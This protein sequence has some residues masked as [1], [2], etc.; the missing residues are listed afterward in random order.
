[1]TTTT[2][3][4]APSRASG[5]RWAGLLLAA[6]AAVLAVLLPAGTASASGVPAAQTRVGASHPAVVH[7]VGVAEHI[8]AGQRRSRAPSQLQIVSGHCVATEAGDGAIA[9][10]P[11][12]EKAW[13]V[14]DRVRAKGA[15]TP[16]YKG[17][18]VFENLE[19]RLPGA[20]GAG[21]AISYREWDVNPYVKGVDRGPQRLV[22]CSDGSAHYTGDHYGSFLQFWGAP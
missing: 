10:G 11:G 13:S 15:P 14:F 21:N 6:L 17:G 20:D 3:T 5:R 22:T 8:A 7:I 9:F 19:G 4:G 2:R 18:S 1:M 16:G 12:T